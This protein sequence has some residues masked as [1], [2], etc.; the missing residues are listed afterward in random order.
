M[1]K[2]ARPPCGL[3][4][5]PHWILSPWTR[6]LPWT[7]RVFV[8]FSEIFAYYATTALNLVF[9]RQKN[10]SRHHHHPS[11]TLVLHHRATA[12][13]LIS[14]VASRQDPAAG[15]QPVHLGHGVTWKM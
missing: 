15:G 8:S 9:Q 14:T 3:P 5:L 1:P 2:K 12:G 13:M 7:V 10:M 11:A 4:A 6:M